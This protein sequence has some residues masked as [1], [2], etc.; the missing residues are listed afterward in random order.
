MRAVPSWHGGWVGRRSR[1]GDGGF[2]RALW[3]RRGAGRLPTECTISWGNRVSG[4]KNLIMGLWARQPFR[5][6]EKFVASLRRTAYAGDVCICV[7]DVSAETIALLRAHHIIVERASLSAQPRMTALSS[8]YFTYLDFLTRHRDEYANVMLTDPGATVFQSDPFAA[9]L[10]ADI[11]YTQN[12]CRLG[13]SAVD[14]D[15]VVQAYGESVAHNMRDCVVSSA[16]ATFGTTSGILRYLV[17]MTHEL[18]GRSTPITGAID[19]G[20][21]NYVVHMRPLRNAWFDPGAS[22]V[23]AMGNLPDASAQISERGVLID[24]R[25][26]SVLLQWDRNTTTLKYVRSAPRFRLDEMMGSQ[27]APPGTACT[28]P[29]AAQEPMAATDAVIAYYHRERD[30]EWLP[31][32]LGSLRCVSDSVAVHCVGDFDRNE[33]SLLSQHRCIAHR[34]PATETTVAEN[35]AHFYLSQ[36]LDQLAAEPAALPEQV[37]VLD[38]VRAVFPRD[39]FQSKTIGLSVFAEGPTRI[40]ESPFNR[41]RL[42][43]FVTPDQHQLQCPILSSALLRGPLLVVREFYRHLLAELIGRTELMNIDKV[44]QGAVNKLC[45]GGSLAFPVIAHPNGAEA[46]FDFWPSGLAI[47]VRHGVRIGGTVPGIVLG[48]HTETELMMKLRVDLN[49]PTQ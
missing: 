48:W 41:D 20:V 4:T 22:F 31:M 7:A 5:P 47:D 12:R 40:G 26:A 43:F 27:R 29:L 24:G 30:A 9:P 17:A 15:T 6:L 1:P 32:F 14:H 35:V 33:Q 13:E 37:L 19:R 45:H 16:G 49:L 11:V 18:S 8:R 10:P 21:H 3:R 46:Y 23:A 36:V 38:N 44:I 42:A 2:R 25:L 39:P 28:P 34:T